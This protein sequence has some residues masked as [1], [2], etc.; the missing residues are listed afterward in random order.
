[1]VDIPRFAKPFLKKEEMQKDLMVTIITDPVK[2]PKFKSPVVC[3]VE[4]PDG[5][6]KML[7]MNKT[8]M[9]NLAAKFQEPGDNAY[10]THLW[11]GKQIVCLGEQKIGNMTCVPWDGVV[12]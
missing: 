9:N 1:M 4:M 11:T 12:L 7:G 2:D 8:T 3:E 5:S 10:R 6:V